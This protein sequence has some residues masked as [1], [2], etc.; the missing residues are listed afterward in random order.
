MAAYNTPG[1]SIKMRRIGKGMPPE[2]RLRIRLL[3]VPSK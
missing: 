2:R 1:R 3:G